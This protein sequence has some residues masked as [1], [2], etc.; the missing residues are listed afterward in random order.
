MA[1]LLMTPPNVLLE[2]TPDV[3]GYVPFWYFFSALAVTAIGL[4][5]YLV[6]RVFSLVRLRISLVAGGLGGL[7]V[8]KLFGWQAPF[9][10]QRL[11]EF[12]LIG[13]VAALAFWLVVSRGLPNPP[14]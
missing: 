10:P 14:K 9:E 4:P 8:P 12:A 6:L 2:Q 13:V 1:F 7:L 5:L 11:L 3:L